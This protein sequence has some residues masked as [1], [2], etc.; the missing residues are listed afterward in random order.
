MYSIH[1][2]ENYL[3]TF[4]FQL[5]IGLQNCPSKWFF[6]WLIGSADLIFCL[7]V[8]FVS[9]LL[10]DLF[11]YIHMTDSAHILHML[12]FNWS[13]SNE[14]PT[15]FFRPFDRGC[16]WRPLP[17]SILA[18]FFACV[19]NARLIHKI[20]IFCLFLQYYWFLF[21]NFGRFLIHCAAF[22]YSFH[23]ASLCLLPTSGATPSVYN[24]F[25]HSNLF[26][27]VDLVHT[28][29]FF[30]GS[31]LPPFSTLRY[32]C[33]RSF[34]CCWRPH[35]RRF[36]RHLVIHQTPHAELLFTFLCIHFSISLAVVNCTS[37]L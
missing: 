7:Y 1:H 28:V 30:A 15:K 17:S 36:E 9:F 18:W 6:L 27:A 26:I 8:L 21:L 2:S 16:Y 19:V 24:R 20:L 35:S 31:V 25:L 32:D 12:S 23:P 13:H 14:H 10:R 37:M 4:W 34:S 3:I 33:G 5:I 22:M 29:D 11:P